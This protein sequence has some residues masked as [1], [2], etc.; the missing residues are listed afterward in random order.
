MPGTAPSSTAKSQ[1]AK[2]PE[3]V[4]LVL[5]DAGGAVLEASLETATGLDGETIGAINLATKQALSRC[6]NALALGPLQRFTVTG[7]R[8]ASLVS[9]FDHQLLGVFIDP[10]KPIGAFERKLADALE[11]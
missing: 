10:T 6:G 1:I 3:V 11:R 9:V 5:T 8:R 4:G 7:P 2:L